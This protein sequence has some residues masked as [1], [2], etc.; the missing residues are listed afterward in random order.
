MLSRAFLADL[1]TYEYLDKTCGIQLDGE[2][3][4]LIIHILWI[5]N[6]FLFAERIEELQQ[7]YWLC[8]WILQRMVFNCNILSYLQVKYWTEASVWSHFGSVVSMFE[9]QS[10]NPNTGL[11]CFQIYILKQNNLSLVICVAISLSLGWRK[12]HPP[13]QT[14]WY[15]HTDLQ[16]N[17]VLFLYPTV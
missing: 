14:K 5:D 6:L 2:D 12:D 16:M 3:E 11:P 10:S 15:C 4:L 13:P 8:V 17:V 1:L 9:S 7:F